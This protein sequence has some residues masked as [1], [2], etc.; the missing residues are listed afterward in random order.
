MELA[1]DRFEKASLP[2]PGNGTGKRASMKW[3]ELPEERG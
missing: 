3:C 1:K 2:D